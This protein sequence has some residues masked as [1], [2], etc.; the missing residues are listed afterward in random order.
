MPYVL[1]FNRST[2]EKKIIKACEY[3]EIKNKS[4]NGFIDWILAL[5][6]KTKIPHKI[7]D[8]TSISDKDIEKLSPMALADP[9]TPGNPKK[10]NL[11]DFINMYSNSI[12]GKLF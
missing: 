8:T 2:I 1:T 11:E 4:F 6:E 3:L 9:C 5:R 7:S 10:L 12:N